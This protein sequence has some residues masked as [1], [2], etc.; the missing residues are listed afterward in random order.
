[1]VSHKVTHIC[2]MLQKED[3]PVN[4]KSQ[5]HIRP[6]DVREGRRTGEC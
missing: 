6:Q 4:G 2:F 1:M 5:S 3:R